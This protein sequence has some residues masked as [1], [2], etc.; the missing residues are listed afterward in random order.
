[1]IAVSSLCTVSSSMWAFLLTVDLHPGLQQL[2]T[3]LFQ[4]PLALLQ[5]A[6]LMI[7]H[8]LQLLVQLH[9][10]LDYYNTEIKDQTVV[11]CPLL[12]HWLQASPSVQWLHWL[13]LTPRNTSVPA[14]WSVRGSSLWRSFGGE[15]DVPVPAP[16]SPSCI[17]STANFTIEYITLPL[18][19]EVACFFSLTWRDRISS[20][21][22]LSSCSL[23]SATNLL[24]DWEIQSAL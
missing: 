23:L 21:S 4:L 18:N 10:L 8:I 15:A 12:Y 14:D 19:Q 11:S 1:M 24:L 5:L 16:S 9:S 2:L 13:V 6:L 20:F 3:A 17:G 22:A 7:I